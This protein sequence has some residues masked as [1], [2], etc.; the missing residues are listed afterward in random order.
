MPTDDQIRRKY[1]LPGDTPIRH[2][3]PSQEEMAAKPSFLLKV[4]KALGYEEWMWKSTRGKILAVIILVP[5]GATI[6]GWWAPKV[7]LGWSLAEPYVRTITLS[8]VEFGSRMV[9]FLPEPPGP[10]V[11]PVERGAIPSKLLALEFDY[12]IDSGG[13]IDLWRVVQAR[14]DHAAGGFGPQPLRYPSRW[15]SEGHVTYAAGSLIQAITEMVVA[16]SA[17]LVSRHWTAVRASLPGGTPQLSYCDL[18]IAD[19]AIFDVSATR[20]AGDRWLAS[21]ASCVLR[22]PSLVR[23]GESSYVLNLTHPDA[24]SLVIE[25][26]LPLPAFPGEPLWFLAVSNG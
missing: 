21:G 6:V 26:T 11:A 19:T 7:Q 12:P 22:V 5:A 20:A 1:S 25:E 13:R 10:D 8:G 14:H 16:P 17:A 2:S 9:G 15:V 23:P 3:M 24:E 4:A 18:G